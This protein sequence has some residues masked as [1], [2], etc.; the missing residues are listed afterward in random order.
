MDFSEGVVQEDWKEH[1]HD[2]VVE[3]RIRDKD[4]GLVPIPAP[5]EY[6][7]EPVEDRAPEY[8][9]GKALGRMSPPRDV[10]DV[11]EGDMLVLETDVPPKV[12]M[13]VNMD[14]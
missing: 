2:K 4:R 3:K 11:D 6:S 9:F 7:P 1:E 5:G 10:D 13:L 8:D 12:P 14:K